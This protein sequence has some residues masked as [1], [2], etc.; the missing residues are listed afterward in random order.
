MGF[1]KIENTAGFTNEDLFEKL[2]AVKVSFGVPVMG[3]IKGT[4]SVMY[5]KVSEQFDLFVR[6]DGKNVI[7]G[8][9][10]TDGVSSAATALNMGLDLFLG[11]KDSGTSDADH[12]VNE[13]AEIIGRLEKGEEVTESKEEASVKTSSGE[14]MEFYM[15]QKAISIKPKFDIFDAQEAQV[16]HVE[17]DLARLN[18]SIQ[19]N[20]EEVAKLKKKL[21][22]VMPEYTILAKGKEVGKIKKK[23]KLTNPELKGTINGQELKIVGDLFGF[24]F[25]IQV[26]ASTIG[27]VD[28][29]SQLWQDTYRICVFDESY[30]DIMAALAI[31]CDNV[32]DAENN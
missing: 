24:D 28:T 12:A 17:G 21:I 5:K 32:V 8:K 26:G 18:F 1:A 7:M 3:D 31:I 22:A 14:K 23:M 25:D 11:H 13:L 15:N 16:Y 27:H 6:V 2:S 20:G 10:G 29:V 30:Q 4:P 9:I 19:R